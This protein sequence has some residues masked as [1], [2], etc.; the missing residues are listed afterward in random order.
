MLCSRLLFRSLAR[1]FFYSSFILLFLLDW[2]YNPSKVLFLNMLEEGKLE[3]LLKLKQ[4]TLKE[5][6]HSVYLDFFVCLSQD[7]FV[8][9][10]LQIANKTCK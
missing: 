3:V 2:G 6:P 7:Y 8:S 4:C 5:A 9:K 1:R 10:K